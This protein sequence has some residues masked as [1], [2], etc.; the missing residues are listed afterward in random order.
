MAEK[1]YI[2]YR[3]YQR[4]EVRG[5]N[6]SRRLFP[7]M[8]ALILLMGA[9][10]AFATPVSAGINPQPALTC[11]LDPSSQEARV[12]ESA[13]GTVQFTGS[14]RVD[15]LPVERIVVTLLSSI[16]A[17]WASQCS[18]SS[19]VITDTQA[20]SFS[21]T[22]II[23]QATPS[24]IIGN[25][26]IDAKGTGGGFNVVTSATVIITVKPYYRV[27]MESDMP[28]KEI[29]PGTQAF[30]SF[31]LWNV[32]NAIDSYE[33]E[34]VNLKDLVTKKWTV[35]LSS[36][37]VAKINPNEYKTVRI[38]AQSPRDWT[39]WKSEPTMINVKSSSLNAKEEQTVVTQ[40][41]PLYA[42][43]KGFYIPG[44]DPIFMIAALAMGAVLL[45]KK[46][47]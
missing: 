22:G 32:G 3:Q 40:S 38:T 6:I 35:T 24:N 30:Y 4:K 16:D 47:Q 11:T 29:S 46:R 5:M 21:V 31:K 34:I 42:Y 17:G 1:H 25:L 20:H 10:L 18:P 19:L 44:F 28:Y 41:F 2:A 45:K 39:I 27:M 9:L 36:T 33:M 14:V 26:K 43:E 23:P 13:Q 12:S 37:Q 15:K 7:G 8:A